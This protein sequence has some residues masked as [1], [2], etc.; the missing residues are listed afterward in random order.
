MRR[1]KIANHLTLVRRQIVHNDA[2]LPR[3]RTR[4]CGRVC[5][6]LCQIPSLAIYLANPILAPVDYDR[7]PRNECRII[8]RQEE[9]CT[10]N[11]P[12]FSQPLDG[13]QVPGV[14]LLLVRLW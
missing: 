6:A 7:L 9:H 5:G 2:D 12:R 1:Q 3:R 11:I 10:R 4:L 14:A 8:A 13:L